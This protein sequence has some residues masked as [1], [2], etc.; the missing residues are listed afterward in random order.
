MKLGTSQL[1]G[2]REA[3]R[4]Q[5]SLAMTGLEM[6]TQRYLWFLPQTS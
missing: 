2:D 6:A 5:A 3:G 1:G 4:G